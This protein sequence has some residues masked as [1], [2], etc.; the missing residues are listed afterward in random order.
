MGKKIIAIV[1]MEP[2]RERY[3]PVEFRVGANGVTS[4]EYFNTNYGDHGIGEYKVYIG[5]KHFMSMS[6]RAVAEIYY[7]QT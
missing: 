7:D 6:H 2:M 3:Y 4:I 5:D 1:G